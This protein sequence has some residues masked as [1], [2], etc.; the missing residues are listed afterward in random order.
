MRDCVRCHSKFIT[1][2]NNLNKKQL[3]FNVV[4]L[5]VFFLALQK[6]YGIIDN[7][8]YVSRSLSLSL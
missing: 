8:I 6:S 7:N 2:Q 3:V 1:T 4:G 5:F